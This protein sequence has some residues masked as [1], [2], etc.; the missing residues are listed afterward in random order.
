[1]SLVFDRNEIVRL[2]AGE[3][4]K[5]QKGLLRVISGF[6]SIEIPRQRDPDTYGQIATR[7]VGPEGYIGHE[8][9]DGKDS[10]ALVRALEPAL[11]EFR[12]LSTLRGRFNKLSA[13]ERAEAYERLFLETAAALRDAYAALTRLK[14]LNA[15]QRAFVALHKLKAVTKQGDIVAYNREGLAAM[16]GIAATESV[17]RTL[18]T[19]SLSGLIERISHREVR[20]KQPVGEYKKLLDAYL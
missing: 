11:L 14:S 15:D 8:T 7:F 17:S 1:M 12:P 16:S 3:L 2:K 18:A 19:L 4:F 10:L 9:L 5:P 20:L 6:V 13:D